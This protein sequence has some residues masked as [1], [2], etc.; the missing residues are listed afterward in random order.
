[1]AVG[2]LTVRVSADISAMRAE[3]KK[4]NKQINTLSKQVRK[5]NKDWAK[6]RSLVTKAA[7]ALASFYAVTRGIKAFT[8]FMSESAKMGAEI[9]DLS[10][11]L[12][13]SATEFQAFNYAMQQAG[14]TTSQTQDAVKTLNKIIGELKSGTSTTGADVFQQLGL[15]P[16]KLGTS[17][18]AI[19]RVIESLSQIKD[20][21]QRNAM[22]AKLFG[23]EAGRVMSGIIAKTDEYKKNLEEGLGIALGDKEVTQLK[24]LD[25]QLTKLQIVWDNFK[26]S[27]AGS[28]IGAA[29]SV[30]LGKLSDKLADGSKE[31]RKMDNDTIETMGDI[32]GF[33]AVIGQFGSIVSSAFKIA[34]NGVALFGAT[35]MKI[36]YQIKA[37]FLE[38]IK[39]IAGVWNDL[40]GEMAGA[41]KITAGSRGADWARVLGWSD[42]TVSK[43][44]SF[45]NK[46]EGAKINLKG[47]DAQIKQSQMLTTVWAQGESKAAQ[48]VV[49]ATNTLKDNLVNPLDTFSNAKSG[50][51]KAIKKE[52]KEATE[53]ARNAGKVI[54]DNNGKIHRTGGAARSAG[55][56][57]K[58]AAKDAQSDWQKLGQMIGDKLIG[59][60]ESMFD[61][62]MDGSKNF[63]DTLKDLAKEIGK[64][65]I[66]ILF[67][68]KLRKAMGGLFGGV[69]S[70]GSVSAPAVTAY[71]KGGIVNQPTVFTH[72][73]GVGIMGESGAEAI[74]PLKREGGVLGVQAS[75]PEVNVNVINNSN[76]NVD[77]KQNS[78]GSLDIIIAEVSKQI[79][80]GGIVGDSIEQR[81]GL[82]KR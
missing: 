64:M 42:E 70:V 65:M 33:L 62:L 27:I 53:Q 61:S 46:I 47:F 48:A 7:A 52:M 40:V 32:A 12:G 28:A 26:N 50:A 20:V 43:I 69:S 74:L 29:F 71:A 54:D 79:M 59:A 73:G 9:Y 14:G 78:D 23:E 60:F 4:A 8:S 45:A 6:F 72:S 31:I 24:R 17:N 75:K 41:L 30:A 10:K 18:E 66:K 1:M 82:Q 38:M 68:D 44:N 51:I 35:A 67:F 34:G 39:A 3:L 11:Q 49:D 2:A 76:S 19:Q 37:G 13:M 80:F 55:K 21:Q 57:M 63:K 15:D 25:G 5:S 58:R 56:A 81:Y 16:T 77:V 36:F 22:A